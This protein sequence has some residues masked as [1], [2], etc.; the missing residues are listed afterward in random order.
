[1]LAWC[2]A[3]QAEAIRAAMVQAFRNHGL[4]SDAWVSSLDAAGA[5]VEAA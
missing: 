2:E 4:E 3:P 1:V 5:R